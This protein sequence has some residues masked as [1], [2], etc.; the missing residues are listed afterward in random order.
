MHC[1]FRQRSGSI[2]VGVAA[3]SLGAA[4]I[5]AWTAVPRAGA[6]GGVREP[7]FTEEFFIEHCSFAAQGS[8]LFFSLKPGYQLYLAGDDRGESVELFITVLDET[9]DIELEIDDE[10]K[11]VRTRVIEEREFKDG[12]LFEISRNYYAMC[13]TTGSV[14]YFGEDVCFYEDD[15]CVS[16]DGSWLAGESG[17]TPGII[18][19]GTFLLGARYYQE[20]A[21][22]IAL[23]RAEHVE[24]DVEIE[25]PAGRFEDCVVVLESSAIEPNAE[26]EKVYA[27]GVGLVKDDVLELVSYGFI[28]D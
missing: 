27:P 26:S 1:F 21:P 13:R 14:F 8:N 28:D 10:I 3:V 15:E 7:E 9:L 19:P 11:R 6:G 5:A 25:L 20:Q 18:M 23:D 17:A 12:E 24:M 22:G 2:R 4:G 16:T